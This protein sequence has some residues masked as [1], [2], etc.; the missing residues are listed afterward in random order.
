[1][2]KNDQ[3]TYKAREKA[4]WYL[5]KLYIPLLYTYICTYIYIEIERERSA[6]IEHSIEI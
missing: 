5:H 3:A 2:R 1:M 4:L 6:T